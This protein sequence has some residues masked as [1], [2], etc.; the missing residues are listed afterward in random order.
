[1]R[2]IQVQCYYWKRIRPKSVGQRIIGGE[3][4]VIEEYPFAVS[5]QNNVTIFGHDVEHFCGGSIISDTW[6]ITSAQCALS[7]N[8]RE[9]HIRAGSTYYYKNVFDKLKQPIKLP[10]KDQK[11]KDGVEITIV[12]WGATQNLRPMSENLQKTNILKISNEEC[13]LTYG[14]QLTDRMFCII[15]DDSKPCVGDSGSSA[16]INNTLIGIASWSEAC[17]FSYPTAYTNLSEMI[18]WIKENTEIS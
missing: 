6:I 2:E 17:G 12:G 15:S 3:D 8:V 5:L 18:D 7:I 13:T 11:I 1:M 10:E 9:F 14:Y 4:A 16:V